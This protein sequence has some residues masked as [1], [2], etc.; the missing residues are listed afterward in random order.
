MLHNAV[1]QAVEG[2]DRQTAAGREAL[3]RVRERLG[4]PRART[5]VAQ[6]EGSGAGPTP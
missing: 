6:A 1:F 5:G 4:R 2:D 3:D